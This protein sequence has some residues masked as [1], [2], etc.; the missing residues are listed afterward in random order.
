[1]SDTIPEIA[2]S[3][4]VVALTTLTV[5]FV[6]GLLFCHFNLQQNKNR[7]LQYLYIRIIILPAVYAIS[8]SLSFFIPHHIGFFHILRATY[9]AYVMFCFYALIVAYNGGLRH[10]Q[11]FVEDATA[12]LVHKDL[13]DEERRQ[14]IIFCRFCPTCGFCGC[15]FFRMTR[16]TKCCC[17]SSATAL[18]VWKW[19]VLQFLVVNPTV[20]AALAILHYEHLLIQVEWWVRPIA[21]ISV[22][23]AFCGL[24]NLVVAFLPKLNRPPDNRPGW[25]SGNV[26]DV[27]LDDD[28]TL[29]A[30]W[31][32]LAVKLV[33]G[34][35]LWQEVF[36]H[37]LVK[38][39][40]VQGWSCYW[41]PADGNQ[42]WQDVPSSGTRSLILAVLIEMLLLAAFNIKVF[43]ANDKVLQLRRVESKTVAALRSTQRMTQT[44]R[45]PCSAIILWQFDEEVIHGTR[46]CCFR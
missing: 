43:S 13:P 5:I 39:G 33:V 11:D 9:E 7:R 24:I 26:V 12:K 46:P 41:S 44:E 37:V 28:T 2:L 42:C 19:M 17:I 34:L 32:L 6:V 20:S 23:I 10:A 21:L 25:L 3:V 38:G 29:R 22:V 27:E 18:T 36:F 4:T 15:R 40:I 35:T 45:K 8:A 16:R 1:M 31:K 14:H 30:E